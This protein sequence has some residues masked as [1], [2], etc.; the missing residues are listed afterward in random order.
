MD[1]GSTSSSGGGGVAAQDDQR[2]SD[3]SDVSGPNRLAAAIEEAIVDLEARL[4]DAETRA[5]R[6]PLNRELHRRKQLLAWCKTRA[7]YVP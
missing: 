3:V 1:E 6:R 5:A 4:A 7:G 2:F